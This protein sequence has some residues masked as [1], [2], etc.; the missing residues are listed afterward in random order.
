MNKCLLPG[1][2][3]LEKVWSTSTET[4]VAFEMATRS[5]GSA[6]ADW[7]LFGSEDD[8]ACGEDMTGTVNEDGT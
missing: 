6:L 1:S 4:P 2:E 7:E 8:G 5:T 3:I